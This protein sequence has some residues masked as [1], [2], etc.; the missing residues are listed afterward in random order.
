MRYGAF[1]RE[2]EGGRDRNGLIPASPLPVVL[3]IFSPSP[4]HQYQ[5]PSQ[6]DDD[7][8]LP[9]PQTTGNLVLKPSL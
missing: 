4:Y 9:G 7:G 3:A 8:R 1:L 6:H 5:H 2:Y